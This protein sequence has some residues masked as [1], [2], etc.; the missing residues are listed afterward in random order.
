MNRRW[1]F[2]V[3]LA[4]GLL[5]VG[6]WAW[7]DLSGSKHDFSHAEWANGDRCGACHGPASSVPTTAPLWDPNADL[8]RRF[9]PGRGSNKPGGEAIGVLSLDNHPPA[10]AIS[11]ILALDSVDRVW[12]VNLPPAGEMPAWMGG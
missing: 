5:C 4:T 6:T 8:R 7:A 11:A 2:G 9:G 12:I 3:S 1:V 10:E